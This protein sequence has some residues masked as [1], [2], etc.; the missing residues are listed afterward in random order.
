MKQTTPPWSARQQWH[1]SFLSK[2]TSY[3]RHASVQTNVVADALSRLPPMSA[4][5][6]IKEPAIA[7]P[8]R[9]E[10]HASIIANKP[11]PP[12]ISDKAD[13]PGDQPA[14]LPPPRRPPFDYVALAAAQ[15][16]C[17]DVRSMQA[18]PS[19][20]IVDRPVGGTKL[21]GDVSTGSFRPLLPA[22]FRSAA[23]RALHGI[24]HPGVRATTR[25]VKA[26]FCWPRMGKDVTAFAQSCLGCQ[27]GKIHRHVALQPEFIA[28]PH[29]QFSHIHMDLVGPLPKSAG[30]N[31]LFTIIDR[32]TRWPEAIP[33]SSTSAADCAAALFVGWIQRFGIPSTI[34]SDRGPQF[35]S[36]LW[37]ALCR[38]L[39]IK[40]SPITAYHPQSNGLVKRF[41]RRLKDALRVRAAEAD[42]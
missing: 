14:S 3:L 18:S 22:A 1:L 39:E 12:T 32:T 31:Y 29:R 17:P 4:A 10:L 16:D 9:S 41:Q 36:T 5:A 42:W 13:P 19:L 34:T 25:L 15:R 27:R 8:F 30:C 33:L 11:V 40:H 24:H 37:S 6:D 20:R 28:V 21:L 23:I 2:F 7:A 38:L 26:S 35:T